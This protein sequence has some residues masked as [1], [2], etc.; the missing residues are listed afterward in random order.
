[1]RNKRSYDPLFKSIK[2]KY[3]KHRRAETDESQPIFVIGEPVDEDYYQNM[4]RFLQTIRVNNSN[5]KEIVYRRMKE[6][7]INRLQWIHRDHPSITQIFEIFPKYLG[8]IE[9]VI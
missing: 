2:R 9:I 5:D 4:I 7:E 1:M 8:H 3:K 6:I